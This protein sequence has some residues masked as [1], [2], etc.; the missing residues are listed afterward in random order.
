MMPFRIFH[1]PLKRTNIRFFPD[2]R[3]IFQIASVSGRINAINDMLG[4]SESMNKA[5]Q[6]LRQPISRNVQKMGIALLSLIILG[7]LLRVDAAFSDDN[8]HINQG[9]LKQAEDKW[10]KEAPARL[11]AWENIVRSGRNNSDRDKL[12]KV[13]AFMNKTMTYAEDITIWGVPDYW[14]TPLEFV[15][16]GAGDCEEYAIAKYFTLKAMGIPDD[17]LNIAY[18]KALQLNRSHMVLTYVSKPGDEPLILD[19]LNDSI[20]SA[21]ERRDLTP[22]FSFNGTVLWM[23]RQ[24]GE[25]EVTDSSRLRPWRDLLKRISENNL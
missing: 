10:G 24:R 20:K 11:I 3:D 4:G 12:E 6:R 23:A 21:S 8:F 17:K 1:V 22:I 15:S 7:G 16:R 19:N 9:V 25:G 2:R 18:V 14:A 5:L 13:N